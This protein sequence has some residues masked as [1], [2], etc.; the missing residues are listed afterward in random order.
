MCLRTS[1]SR[2]QP[3]APTGKLPPASDGTSSQLAGVRSSSKQLSTHSVQWPLGVNV[4]PKEGGLSQWLLLFQQCTSPM[5]FLSEVIFLGASPEVQWLRICRPMQGTL[6]W[7]LVWEDPTF[8][9][10]TKPKHQNYWSPHALDPV[11]CN[12]RSH[13]S[14]NPI[15]HKKE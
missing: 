13:S 15:H 7:S 3:W 2:K 6:V 1:V 12:T 8:F 5:T 14:E 10:A 4:S 9:R 11:L